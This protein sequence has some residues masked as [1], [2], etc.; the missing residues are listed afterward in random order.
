MNKTDMTFD[1]Y[2][3]TPN[4]LDSDVSI[5]IF[6]VI[7]RFWRAYV[8]MYRTVVPKAVKTVTIISKLST[9]YLVSNTVT[10]IN[11]AS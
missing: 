8:N 10:N 4:Y 7:L 11:D 1:L 5:E 3:S 2:Q 9:K 6:D